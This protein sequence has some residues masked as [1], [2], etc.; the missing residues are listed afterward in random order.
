MIKSNNL[1]CLLL[2][3]LTTII[4]PPVFAQDIAGYSK[5]EVKDLSKKV[6]DQI[7]FLEYFLNTVGSKDTPARDK[8]VIIRESYSKIFRD[9]KVQVEDDL[10]LDRQVITN[11]DITSYLKDIEFFFKDA[12]FKF[13]VR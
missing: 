8:D 2:L 11:K 6:E 13:K 10:L 3:L 5:Q 9:G 12:S 1:R 4:Y 7:L